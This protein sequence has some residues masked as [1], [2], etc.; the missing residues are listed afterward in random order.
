MN[1]TT[2]RTL[3]KVLKRTVSGIK[4]C[5]VNETDGSIRSMLCGNF[6]PGDLLKENYRGALRPPLPLPSY[7]AK[8]VLAAP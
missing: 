2:I 4:L 8:H 3:K 1:K 5:I 7:A 6:E